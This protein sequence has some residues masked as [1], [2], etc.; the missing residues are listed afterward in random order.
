M[1]PDYRGSAAAN[2]PATPRRAGP[3]EIS[4]KRQ[5][6][7]YSQGWMEPAGRHAENAGGNYGERQEAQ[8]EIQAHPVNQIENAVAG[9]DSKASDQ[10]PAQ[11]REA[12]IPA[13][14]DN[15]GRDGSPGCA[16]RATRRLG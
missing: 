7:H 9:G 14:R 5:Y 6:H 15:L 1:E 11:I 12:M 13:D 16:A 2:P 8:P 10:A 3:G 4:Q